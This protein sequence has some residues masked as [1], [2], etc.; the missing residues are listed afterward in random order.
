MEGGAEVVVT[1][2]TMLT[3]DLTALWGDASQRPDRRT[4]QNVSI[5]CGYFQWARFSRPATKRHFHSLPDIYVSVGAQ[6]HSSFVSE[7]G[8]GKAYLAWNLKSF[9]SPDSYFM[10]LLSNV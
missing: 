6:C 8:D 10:C 3:I 9:I 2:L 5:F 1:Y 4:V 7:A